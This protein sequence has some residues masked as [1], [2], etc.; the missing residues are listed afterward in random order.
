MYGRGSFLFL[1]KGWWLV[2]DWFGW[3]GFSAVA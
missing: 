2:T 3:D 1:L